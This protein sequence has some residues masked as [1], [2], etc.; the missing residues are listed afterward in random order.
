MTKTR[1]GTYTYCSEVI[2]L[3]LSVLSWRLLLK[4]R[5]HYPCWIIKLL[6]LYM[7]DASIYDL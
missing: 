3:V 4:P 6:L 7:I 5:A 1:T 2:K